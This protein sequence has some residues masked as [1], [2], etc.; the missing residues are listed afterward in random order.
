M[1]ARDSRGAQDMRGVWASRAVEESPEKLACAATRLCPPRKREAGRPEPE[2]DS[3]A[4]DLN[5]G[6]EGL[7]ANFCYPTDPKERSGTF[8]SSQR[9][10]RGLAEA[11]SPLM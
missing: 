5:L 6:S 7:R 10:T 11:T 8:E 9:E 2:E 3:A 1:S 4:R